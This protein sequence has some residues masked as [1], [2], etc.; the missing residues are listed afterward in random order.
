MEWGKLGLVVL[1]SGLAS[2]MTDWFF[3]GILF[4][5]KYNAYPEVWRAS[6]GQSETRNIVISI[7][8]SFLACAAVALGL[9]FF[10]ITGWDKMFLFVVVVWA[11]GPLPTMVTNA[12]FMKLHPLV[13]VSN[14]LGWLVKLL[15]VAIAAALLL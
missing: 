12:L 5:D 1:V 14:S 8:L 3:S 13:V 4:H 15:L 6:V 7:L 9:K 11:A 10:A 2:S